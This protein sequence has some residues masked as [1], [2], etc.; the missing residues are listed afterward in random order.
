MARRKSLSTLLTEKCAEPVDGTVLVEEWPFTVSNHFHDI[1]Q[2]YMV[3]L[4]WA[5]KVMRLVE[6]QP[7][8]Q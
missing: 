7:K 8:T 5:L 6:A 4:S 2:C 3:E 1:S